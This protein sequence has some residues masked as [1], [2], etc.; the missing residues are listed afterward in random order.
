VVSN[1]LAHVHEQIDLLKQF[2]GRHLALTLLHD[3]LSFGPAVYF[4]RLTEPSPEVLE[5][6]RQLDNAILD[7]FQTIT[8]VGLKPGTT[9]IPDLDFAT[10]PTPLDVAQWQV[11]VKRGGLGLRSVQ[12]HAPLAY[13]AS[14][15]YAVQKIHDRRAPHLPSDF[16]ELP[17]SFNTSHFLR[18]IDIA[19]LSLEQRWLRHYAE[20]LHRYSQFREGFALALSQGQEDASGGAAMPASFNTISQFIAAC[21][22]EIPDRRL[23]RFLSKSLDEFDAERILAL[24]T[25]PTQ[26][27]RMMDLRKPGMGLALYPSPAYLRAKAEMGKTSGVLLSNSTLFCMLR[28]RLGI[29]LLTTDAGECVQCGR[30]VRNLDEHL[31]TCM[32]GGKRTSCHD[33]MLQ[34]VH[35]ILHR[36]GCT[37]RIELLP[38]GDESKRMDIV[39]TIGGQLFH[40]DVTVVS[41]HITQTTKTAVVK[42]AEDKKAKYKQLSESVGAT[43]VPAAFD[44]WGNRVAEF[45]RF[46]KHV[47]SLSSVVFPHINIPSAAVQ[48]MVTLGLWRAVGGLL[49]NRIAA[50]SRGAGH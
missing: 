20:P 34:S 3:C 14:L 24:T 7:G 28:V 26:R 41:P 33:S 6:Y 16:I 21:I 10:G 27:R 37:T 18:G 23:Q 13:F 36:L 43:F 12:R 48:T 32:E 17:D 5:V 22:P 4:M 50:G 35:S 25:D 30:H 46:L 2:K 8:A 29:E 45:D 31:M 47:M 49:S 15:R 1:A 38:W 39:A 42:A 40:V 11:G 19:S 44:M 9:T